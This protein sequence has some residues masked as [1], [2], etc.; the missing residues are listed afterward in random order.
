MLL[1]HVPRLAVGICAGMDKI[2]TSSVKM[3]YLAQ[4]RIKSGQEIQAVSF[5]PD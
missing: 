1:S 4:D 2:G 5:V 3:P